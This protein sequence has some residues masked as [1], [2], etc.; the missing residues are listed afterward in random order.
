MENIVLASA[1]LLGGIAVTESEGAI[2]NGL[3]VDSDTEGCAQLVVTGVTLTDTGRGVV[4]TVGDTQ[5]TQLVGQTLGQ[6]LEGGVG[7]EG[8]QQDLSRGDSRGERKDL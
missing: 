4:N 2:L 5:L 3:E 8:N 6:G 1:D 7:R